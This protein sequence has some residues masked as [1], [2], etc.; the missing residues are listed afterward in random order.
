MP[1]TLLDGILL[2]IMCVSGFLAMVRGFSREV[3]A[4]G[5]WV[6]AAVAAYFF[7]PHI[8]G[9]V[10]PYVASISD[11]KTVADIAAAGLVFLAVLII[12]SLVTMKIA[13][14][15]VDSRVGALDRS[16]GFLFGAVRGAALVIIALLFYNWLV[17]DDHQ[18]DWVANAKSKPL[19]DSIGESVIQMIPD[20]AD[21]RLLDSID[22]N[23]D[24]QKV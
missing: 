20:D 5:S 17:P 11:N 3:M 14:T 8:S 9:Y 2:A 19:L 24:D 13:D 7:Y 22:K 1:I 4:I 12:V 21:K 6:A 15:I 16:L 10:A 23:D 18:P